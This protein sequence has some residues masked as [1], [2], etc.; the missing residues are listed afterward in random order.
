MLV[1]KSSKLTSGRKP[2]WV[3]EIEVSFSRATTSGSENSSVVGAYRPKE[4][5][6]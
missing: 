6:E 1:W 2:Y 4:K 3:V 5:S